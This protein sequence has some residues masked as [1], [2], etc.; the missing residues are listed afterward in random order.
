MKTQ[1]KNCISIQ[2]CFNKMNRAHMELLD[3]LD[4][5]TT[6][7]SCF[8]REAILMRKT[9]VTSASMEYS[10]HNTSQIDTNEALRIIQI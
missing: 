3:W 5:Q 2:V 10:N 9:K 4:E 1:M 7:K 6:N 8:I